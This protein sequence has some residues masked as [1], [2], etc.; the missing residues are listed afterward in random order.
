M[1][2]TR[3]C[4]AVLAALTILSLLAWAAQPVGAV[5]TAIDARAGVV[6]AKL[7]T[8][9]SG[10]RTIQFNAKDPK[11][12]KALKVG[13]TVYADLTANTVSLK[14]D[15]QEPCCSIVARQ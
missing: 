12:L 13:Q 5:V 7:K 1:K 11:A 9:T 15:Y 6:T 10:V 4:V 14:P 8:A 3:C 2:I